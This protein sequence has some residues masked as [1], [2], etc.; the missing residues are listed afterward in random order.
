MHHNLHPHNIML[1]DVRLWCALR[2]VLGHALM[3]AFAEYSS[4]VSFKYHATSMYDLMCKHM[5]TVR[6]A[7]TRCILITSAT[8]I[9]H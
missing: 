2:H 4:F 7:H 3:G 6:C 8:R 1:F 5:L 9:H